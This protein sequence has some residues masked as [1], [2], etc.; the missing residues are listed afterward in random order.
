MSQKAQQRKCLQLSIDGKRQRYAGDRRH[1][2]GAPYSDDAEQRRRARYAVLAGL[3]RAGFVPR[4]SRHIGNFLWTQANE[5]P[6]REPKAKIAP[7]QVIVP[8]E[9]FERVNKSIVVLWL[10]EEAFEYRP[11][12]KLSDLV[13]FPVD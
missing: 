9:R 7:Q 3:E 5:A 2:L 8:Y 13:K 10:T 11:I 12:Q 1:R 4:D 6:L